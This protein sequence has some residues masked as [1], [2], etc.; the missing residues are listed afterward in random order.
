MTDL[1]L[2]LYNS[3]KRSVGVNKEIQEGI[4]REMNNVQQGTTPLENYL[5]QNW[6]LLASKKWIH[7]RHVHLPALTSLFPS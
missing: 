5:T 2:G 1:G 7:F 4:D 6:H 3:N